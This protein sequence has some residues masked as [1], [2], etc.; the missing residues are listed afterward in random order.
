MLLSI[1]CDY[2]KNF[3]RRKEGQAMVEYILLIGLIALAVIAV[4]IILGPAISN[5]FQ[6]AVDSVD[7]L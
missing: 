7:A 1:V 2:I 4:L 3:L 5:A 6:D